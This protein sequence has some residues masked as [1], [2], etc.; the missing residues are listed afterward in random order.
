M[1]F[2]HGAF[3][4]PR[5]VRYGVR[6]QAKSEDVPAVPSTGRISTSSDTPHVQKAIRRSAAGVLHTHR[7]ARLLGAPDCC[8]ADPG[9]P[10]S[11]NGLGVSPPAGDR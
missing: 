2:C 3:D 10:R 11:T 1:I 5:L 4:W 8:G 9:W 6:H 7:I